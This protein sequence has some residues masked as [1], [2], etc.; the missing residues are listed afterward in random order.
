MHSV[1]LTFLRQAREHSLW[2]PCLQSKAAAMPGLFRLPNVY[3]QY[4]GSNFQVLV[5]NHQ[6]FSLSFVTYVNLS[7]LT[8]SFDLSYSWF[9][10]YNCLNSCIFPPLINLRF[11]SSEHQYCFSLIQL[12]YD[13]Y[14]Y[15]LFISYLRLNDLER[16]KCLHFT[17]TQPL[18]SS[19]PYFFIQICKKRFES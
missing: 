19:L 8:W 10:L 16:L 17:I 3:I 18:I 5:H 14:V 15:E 6:Q 12:A 1:Y 11:S 4:L 13:S 2:K 7:N 9:Q